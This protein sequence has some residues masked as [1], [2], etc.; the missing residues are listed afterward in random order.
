MKYN[1]KSLEPVIMFLFWLVCFAIICI[2]GISNVFASSYNYNDFSAILYDNYGPELHY[3]L[4]TTVEGGGYTGTI[5]SMTANTSGAAWGFSSPIPL[6]AGRTYSISI[7]PGLYN[8]TSDIVLSTYNRIGVGTTLSNAV[9]SYQNNT[10]AEVITSRSTGKYIQYVFKPTINSNFIVIPFATSS[11]ISNASFALTNISL[12]DLGESGVSETT[13]NNSLNNQTNELNNFIQN[14]TDTIT[15][16][17]DNMQQ[18]IID[19]NKETQDVIKDQFNNCIKEINFNLSQGKYFNKDGSLSDSSDYYY[20]L[21]YIEIKFNTIKISNAVTTTN[22]RLLVY[23]D[24]KNLIDWYTFYGRTITLNSN[25]KYIRFSTT[26]SEPK[27]EYTEQICSNRL[28]ETNNQLGNLNDS[29]NNS[30]STGAT[31]DASNFF[32]NFTTDTFGL[33]SIITAPLSLINSITSSSCSSLKLPLPY[34]DNKYLELPCM[35]FIYTKYFGEFFTIYQTITFG[36]VAYWIIVRIF[37]QVKDFKN[38][39]HD[40]IEVLDL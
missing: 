5:S 33:T 11:N 40:E 9:T 2:V 3:V 14:S 26:S 15:G 18:N 13:I 20:T 37:N 10:N 8:A 16:V 34:L 12:E 19:S 28:D 29:L 38:P 35:E 36:I 6:V 25:A 21:N 30:N 1:D 32:S 31:D 39:D 22:S 7:N 27:L 23:D 24:N 17:I 4:T